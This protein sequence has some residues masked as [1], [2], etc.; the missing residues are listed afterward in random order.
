VHWEQPVAAAAE[1]RPALQDVQEV[2]PA[3][4]YAPAAH[5]SEA[6]ELMPVKAQ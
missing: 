2:A 5:A 6:N 3:A 4:E 1:M